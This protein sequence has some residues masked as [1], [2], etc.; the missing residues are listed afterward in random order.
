MQLVTTEGRL[1]ESSLITGSQWTPDYNELV[2]DFVSGSS[3]KYGE[4]PEDVYNSFCEADSQGSY[5]N[6]NIKG[7]YPF[8][9][10][11]KTQEEEY[12]DSESI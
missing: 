9:K 1:W 5:F 2:I 4:V 11:E 10:I 8:T 7:K 12:G 6:I 3:Y